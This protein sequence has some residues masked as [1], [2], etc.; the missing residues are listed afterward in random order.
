MSIRLVKS[1][2]CSMLPRFPSNCV[3]NTEASLPSAL[4][5]AL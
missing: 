2:T 5:F 4:E 3:V 1:D